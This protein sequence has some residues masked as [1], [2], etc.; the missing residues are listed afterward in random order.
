MTISLPDE[1]RRALAES[2]N[3]LRIEDEQTHSVYF[4]LDEETH[5][6][7][8]LA[9]REQEDWT[10]IQRGLAQREQGLGQ[11]LEEV[12]AEIREECGFSPSP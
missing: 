5:R 1:L 11:S 7:A 6:R 4:M 8:M 10:S 12:D 9:L 2:P 3:G